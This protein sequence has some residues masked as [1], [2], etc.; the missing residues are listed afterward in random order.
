MT[1]TC[2]GSDSLIKT[3][4]VMF[5][6]LTIDAKTMATTFIIITV[7][8]NYSVI[9]GRDWIHVNQKNASMKNTQE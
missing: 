3:K 1:L 9:L 5:V 8:H 6:E 7:E 2:V 4:G